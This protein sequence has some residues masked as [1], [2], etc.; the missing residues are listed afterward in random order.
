MFQPRPARDCFLPRDTEERFRCYRVKDESGG[1]YALEF[2][3]TV[4]PA[5]WSSVP[6]SPSFLAI[7]GPAQHLPGLG[8][9]LARLSRQQVPGGVAFARRSYVQHEPSLGQRTDFVT[10]ARR[11]KDM[12]GA[13]DYGIS[14][15]G[16]RRS[17]S[18]TGATMTTTTPSAGASISPERY[19]ASRRQEPRS[20]STSMAT[21]FR[22]G[23]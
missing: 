17:S 12:I 4:Q 9:K 8:E 6:V 16:P 10:K 7:E 1:T 11:L 5:N 22:R 15:A 21:W 3:E 20:G 18:A 14:L 13:R 23:L 2:A 19:A